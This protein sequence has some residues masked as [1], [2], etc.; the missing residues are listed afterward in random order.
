MKYEYKL[1]RYD[2]PMFRFALDEDAI[3]QNINLMSASGWE[4]VSFTVRADWLGPE[5]S[6]LVLF[7]REK[8]I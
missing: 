7:K 4:V 6:A 3:E 8:K 1:V 5:K 2:R